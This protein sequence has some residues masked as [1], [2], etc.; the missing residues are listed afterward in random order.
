MLQVGVANELTPTFTSRNFSGTPPVGPATAIE[1]K[2]AIVSLL[3]LTAPSSWGALKDSALYVGVDYGPGNAF[4]HA[5][6]GTI[7]VPAANSHMVD[8][9]HLYVGTTINTGLSGLSFGAAWDTVNNCDALNA[10]GVEGY[11]ST[12][13]AYVSYK[14]TDKVT[15]NGRAEYARG[16]AFDNLVVLGK[17]QEAKILAFTGTVQYDL[18]GKNVISRLEVRWDTSADGSPMFGGTAGVPT[19]NNDLMVAAN[20]IYKF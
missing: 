19:K 13:A 6:A 12:M 5:A 1:S 7:N 3:T 11:A 17:A 16:S 20:V 4:S 9:T 2:K 15:I 10:F 8:K 18:W 14:A